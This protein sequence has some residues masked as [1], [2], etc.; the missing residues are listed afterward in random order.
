MRQ[1]IECKDKQEVREDV[2]TLRAPIHID[3]MRHGIRTY[4]YTS[5]RRHETWYSQIHA[6]AHIDLHAHIEMYG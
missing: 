5:D 2:H 3:V 4:T 1:K 6:Y